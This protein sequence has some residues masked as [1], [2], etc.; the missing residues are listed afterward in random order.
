MSPLLDSSRSKAMASV[1]LP[2]PDSPTMP[3]VCPRRTATST[4]STALRMRARLNQ[5][6]ARLNS[7]ESPD[8]AMTGG[9]LR[10][11]G[12]GSPLGSAASRCRVYSCRG[13]VNTVSARPCSTIR[14]WVMTHTRCAIL[15][16]TPRSWV[17]SSNAIPSRSRKSSSNLRICACTVTSNAVVGSSA[18]KRSGSLAK[19]MA[20]ITRCRCPP[21]SWCGYARSRS[22]ASGKATR[23]SSSSVR[24]RASRLPKARWT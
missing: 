8:A 4:W 2:E 20:I 24:S 3:S 5:P 16:T 23:S 18:I 10:V 14:P 13:A 9:A 11:A 21:E 7:T 12:T 6:R 1:V 22:C 17:I 15:R 19:A